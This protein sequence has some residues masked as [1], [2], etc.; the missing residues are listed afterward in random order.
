MKTLF[1]SMVLSLLA[2]LALLAGPAPMPPAAPRPS[3]GDDHDL[4]ILHEARAYRLRLHLQVDGKSFRRGWEDA[5]DRLFHF[6]DANSDGI[7][8]ESEAGR[9]PSATQW[10]QMLQGVAALEPDAPPSVAELR[11]QIGG[12]PVTYAAFSAFYRRSS[13]GPLQIQWG[14]AQDPN[15]NLSPALFALLDTDGDGKLSRAELQAAPAMFG[16]ADA[17]GDEMISSAELLEAQRPL[18]KSKASATPA[19]QGLKETPVLVLDPADP[20]KVLTERLLKVYD[21]DHNGKLSRAEIGLDREVFDRLDANHDGQLDPAE[22]ARWRHEPADVEVLLPLKA[23]EPAFHLLNTDGKTPTGVVRLTLDGT[24][25]IALPG[26]RVEV[27]SLE[28]QGSG[29]QRIR[30]NLRAT[31]GNLSKNGIITGQQIFQPPFT[32]VGVSRI[33]DSNNDGNLS[34]K[35]LDDYLALMEKVMTASTFLTVANRGKNLFEMLDADRD[36]RLSRRELQN[37]WQRLAEWDRDADGAV[38]REELPRQYLLT[39]GHGRPAVQPGSNGPDAF[40]AL[41]PRARP[42]GPLW[43]RKMDRNGDGDVS[44]A[45]F[46]GTME[47]FRRLDTDGD[48]LISVEEA[49]RA[50]QELRKPKR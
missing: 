30:E 38:A 10:Q 31:F 19:P 9:A 34:A 29:S 40:Q 47:Q 46:L 33:A 4:I 16:R 45:E 14:P 23:N 22:L 21:R 26:L 18:N 43:F 42:Q 27:V 7:L 3:P 37:A 39:I 24:L 17:D 28:A 12:G 49:R 35:E 13:A 48:G 25:N 5:A 44:P 8:S 41:R 6:L 32:F 2:G 20:D 15:D 1:A 36:G 50:D 11:G